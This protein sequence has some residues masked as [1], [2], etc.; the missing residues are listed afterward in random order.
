MLQLPR[1]DLRRI[2]PTPTE[3]RAI[4]LAPREAVDGLEFV[5]GNAGREGELGVVGAEAFHGNQG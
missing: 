1:V 2:A 3:E 4:R 5:F